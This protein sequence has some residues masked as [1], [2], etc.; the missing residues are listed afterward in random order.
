MKTDKILIFNIQK[1]SLQDGP[2]I[3]T[4]IFLKGCPLRCQWCSNPESQN[5]FV[6]IFIKDDKKTKID[7]KTDELNFDMDGYIVEDGLFYDLLNRHGICDKKIKYDQV[8]RPV[9]PD[10]LVEIAM[11]DE[12][13]YQ[14]TG[15]G[16]TLS[17]GEPLTQIDLL[18]D[19]IKKLKAKGIH[20]A[21]ETTLYTN[22]GNLAKLYPHLDLFIADCKNWNEDVH[23]NKTGLSNKIIIQ[24]LRELVK[25]AKDYLIRIPVIPDF[26]FSNEDAYEFAKLFQNLGAK[27]VQLLPF[28]QYG[29]GKYESYG[30]KYEY[31]DK[32]ALADSDLDEMVQILRNQ[33]IDAFV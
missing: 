23:M 21:I 15:G 16:V 17:G 18:V 8:G 4:S 13:F 29:K 3:R 11:E 22:P 2:G 32:K 14:S 1:F 20:T 28:H 27:K 19:L 9:D 25:N 30:I 7:V 6:N 33:G 24:N 26:N 5:P 12:V 10:R 31:S